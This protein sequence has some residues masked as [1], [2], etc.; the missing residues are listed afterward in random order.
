MATTLDH[1]TVAPQLKDRMF[2]AAPG[3]TD[4]A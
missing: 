2:V 1:A 4:V 3:W